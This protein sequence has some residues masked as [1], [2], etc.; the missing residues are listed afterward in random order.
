MSWY[1][2]LRV[3]D[4]GPELDRQLALA[5]EA[6]A[7]AVT[8]AVSA[9]G[10]PV[11]VIE[12][13][14][15][16]A[17]HARRAHGRAAAPWMVHPDPAIRAEAAAQLTRLDTWRAS[18]FARHDVADALEGLDT[19]ALD[20][21]DARFL[22]LWRSACRW[23]GAH[24]GDAD[25]A[26]MERLRARAA[27]L[28]AGIS[29]AFTNDVPVFEL[30]EAALAGLPASQVAALAP[31]EAP[32]TRLLRVDDAVLFQ[33]LG[34]LE[35]R[36]VRERIWRRFYD[37]AA[38]AAGPAL[39]ELY[40]VRGAMARLVGEPSWAAL[41]TATGALRSEAGARAMLD[42]L[43]GPAAEA[44]DA[45]RRA[46]E[47]VLA[48][49]LAGTP[50]APWDQHR[51]IRL[52]TRAVGADDGPLRRWLSLETVAAG[53]F[54]LAGEVF[55]VRVEVVGGGD[56]WHED[57]RTLVLIDEATMSR[58]GT[59][60]WDPWAREGKM[61][62]TVAFMDLLEA[63][64]PGED[65]AWPPAMTM[66]VTTA[67]RGDGSAEP[68]VSVFD[69]AVLF[70]EFGH[71]LDFTLGSRQRAVLDDGWWGTDWVEGP[72]FFLEYWARTSEVLGAYASH[73][74][75]EPPPADLVERLGV[76]Q[77]IS[78]VPYLAKY[79]RLGLF[80]L[81]AH[82]PDDVD[83]DEAWRRSQAVIPLWDPVGGFRPFMASMT[84]GGYD[85]ALY[86]V[87][88]AL[89]IRDDLL[90]RMAADGLLDPAAGRRYI[91]RVLRPGPFVAPTERLAAFIGRPVSSAPLVARLEQAIAVAREAAGG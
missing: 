88:Y 55:G 60:L 40:A 49:E 39:R 33:L 4:L 20:A 32:G 27:E 77:A 87:A 64:P 34:D 69:A 58:I 24:L 79:V 82:G 38:D 56:G 68:T 16:A 44:A 9:P 29:M 75:G 12:Q 19:G 81:D 67:D 31:G 45:Y 23:G 90:A 73:P 85:G 18:V 26:T 48:D 53:M 43:R 50:Y 47:V 28:A 42:E 72:S 30:D 70:H 78:D 7:R 8:A 71:V 37:R 51:G 13:L 5:D 76:A 86:G 65:G 80:D 3:D 1:A 57:V 83:L 36:D 91:D 17:R 21:P 66:L 22:E 84:V 10:E 14:D 15:L 11:A 52:L 74:S 59:C 62:G 61:A 63:D 89:A 41:R 54:R 46:M 6:L 25:R 35:R 2:A